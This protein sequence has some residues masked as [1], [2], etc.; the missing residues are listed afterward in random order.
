MGI[1]AARHYKYVEA[2][3]YRVWLRTEDRRTIAEQ[4]CEED[5]RH[6]PY[7]TRSL[8]ALRAY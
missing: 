8:T 1:G 2:K 4:L 7:A 6:P 3:Q 5:V